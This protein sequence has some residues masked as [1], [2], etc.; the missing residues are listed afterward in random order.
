MNL[1]EKID[2]EIEIRNLNDF[3]RLRY[4]YLECCKLF[5]FDTR[6]YYMEMDKKVENEIMNKKFDLTNIEDTSVIC[7]TFVNEILSKLIREFTSLKIDVKNGAHSY[8]DVDCYDN[9]WRLD[10][11]LS[12]LSR[13]KM[14]LFTTGF[15]AY[16]SDFK[17]YLDAVDYLCDYGV[18]KYTE[19]LE[20]NLL[21]KIEWVKDNLNNSDCKYSYSDASYFLRYFTLNE[22]YKSVTYFDSDF[23]FHKIIE[24][25]DYDKY[26]ELNKKDNIFLLDNVSEDRIN[27]LKRTL[28]YNNK[29]DII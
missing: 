23:D 26:Y 22:L 3:E 10:A 19:T 11:T 12:D 6:Y 5:S 21:R 20:M 7:H 13:V 25:F 4:I 1:L 14:N 2:N 29:N 15:Y 27:H 8:I 17:D 18:K 28:K 16:K 9:V 24:I